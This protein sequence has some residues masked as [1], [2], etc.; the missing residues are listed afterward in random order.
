LPEAGARLR[1]AARAALWLALPL[2]LAGCAYFNTYSNAKKFFRDAQEQELDP[3]GKVT[4]QAR[5]KY[6]DSIAKCQKLLDLY[7][8]SRWAD[9]ALLLMSRAYFE[10]Q[11]YNSCLRRLDE[12]DERFP[13]HPFAEEVLFMRGVCHLEGGDESRAIA[14]LQRLEQEYPKSKHL[15]EAITRS[16]D[17]EYRIGNWESAITAY[18]RLLE[19]FDKS[20]WNDEARL[21]IARSQ[22]E[23]KQ[24]SLAVVDLQV[25]ADRG[26]DRGVIFEGQLLEA[27]ILIDLKRYAESRALLDQ[28]EPVAENF[29]SRPQVLLLSAK[30][31]ELEG[32]LPTTVTALENVAKEFPRSNYSAEAY[33]RIGLIR[34][35]REGDLEKALESY[36]LAAK[37]VPRSLY[38]DLA[39]N[40][41]RA[42]QELLDVQKSMGES[43]TDSSAA[44]IQFRMAENQYLRLEDPQA[45]VPEYRK[46]LD[47]YPD[48]ALAPAAA[49][50]LGYIY[51]YALADTAAALEMVDLLT[52]RY[53]ASEAAAFVASWP[54]DL[55]RAGDR[56]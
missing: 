56:P 12:L 9:D 50:A 37:E 38:G 20:D 5:R 19:R 8:N 54:R 7:P 31:R 33:Y 49:Y 30:L 3:Q 34:Q 22:R 24:D 29:K 35:L 2:T 53:P 39:T 11:E 55:G 15:A 13:K 47:D 44:Q 17:A 1:R 23:L 43:P 16:G 42:I 52:S 6:D 28:L 36:D 10:K 32:D 41:H 46:V 14:T 45:A 26:R 48:N 21:R 51:R 4:S 18:R 25:L 27:E 40:K